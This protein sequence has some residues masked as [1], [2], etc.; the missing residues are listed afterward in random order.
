[1]ITNDA[2]DIY[3]S[4][5][6][7]EKGFSHSKGCIFISL[8]YNCEISQILKMIFGGVIDSHIWSWAFCNNVDTIAETINDPELIVEATKGEKKEAFSGR[9][10]LYERID[11]MF[12]ARGHVDLNNPNDPYVNELESRLRHL[13]HKYSHISLNNDSIVFIAKVRP[14]EKES[15]EH[16]INVLRKALDLK[17]PNCILCIVLSKKIHPQINNSNKN[18]HI[19]YIDHYAPSEYTDH[20]C[21]EQWF[22]ILS[23]YA[24]LSQDVFY[25]NIVSNYLNFIKYSKDTNEIDRLRNQIEPIINETIHDRDKLLEYVNMLLLSDNVS[26]KFILDVLMRIDSVNSAFTLANTITNNNY[27]TVNIRPYLDYLWKKKSEPIYQ[28]IFPIILEYANKGDINATWYMGR[29]YRDGICIQ[30]NINESIKW[31]RK[32]CSC[33][34]GQAPRELLGILWADGTDDSL[35]EMVA[36]ANDLAA[37][38]KAEGFGYLGRAYRDGK[39]VKKDAAKAK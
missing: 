35:S 16:Y 25:E 15:V 27:S 34:N 9:G 10:I 14:V 6:T 8:G 2:V 23:N 4:N 13:V 1:M 5:I 26:K 38:G 7:K 3:Y 24:S 32:A 37:S 36:V 20:C 22:R 17:Y 39:G 21:Y 29:L 33:G 11:M 31:M 18:I 28:I 12:H 30:K 19:W